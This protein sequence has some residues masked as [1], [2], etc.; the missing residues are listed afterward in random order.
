MQWR[1]PAILSPSI[2]SPL[3]SPER[4]NSN[5]THCIHVVLVVVAG[6]SVFVGNTAN[7][8]EVEVDSESY[9]LSNVMRFQFFG[10]FPLRREMGC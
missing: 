5:Y 9:I 4:S 8:Y 1:T 3:L 6:V 2:W 7:A 10:G